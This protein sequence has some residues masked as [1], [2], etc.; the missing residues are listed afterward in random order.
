MDHGTGLGVYLRG[1]ARVSGSGGGVGVHPEPPF[2][3]MRAGGG[4]RVE[5][6]YLDASPVVCVAA[7]GDRRIRGGPRG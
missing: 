7:V 5:L 1:Y 2:G 3:Q 4:P 6:P